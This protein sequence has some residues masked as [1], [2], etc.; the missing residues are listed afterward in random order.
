VPGSLSLP[1]HKRQ[2]QKSCISNEEREVSNPRIYI[3]IPTFH[4]QVGGAETQTL[5]QA[6]NLC[7]RGYAATVITFRHK[8]M[9]LPGEVIQGVPVI[10]VAGA[11][12]GG[13][14][15][16]P[17]PIQRLL[18]LLALLVMGWTLWRQRQC[19]DVLHVCQLGLL[20]LPAAI[21]CRLTGKPMLIVIISAAGSGLGKVTKSHGKASLIAGPP[22]ATTS[23][24]QAGRQTLIG[25]DLEGL[26][27]LGR[28]VVRLVRSL[29]H[30]THTPIVILSSRMR[31]YLA[32]HDFDLP[33]VQL[34]SN[35]VD[36]TRFEPAH[37]DTSTGG[38]E[39]VVVCV[40]KLRYEKGID[41]L[42]QAW[43]LVHQQA[44]QARLIIVGSGYLQTQLECMA[45]E[46]G[47]ANSVEFTGLQSDI[48]AQLHRGSL[49][50][51]PSRWEGMPNALLEAMACGLPCVATR[52]S[53]SEDIIQHGVN[54]LL[55]ESED[56]QG[57]AQALLTLLHDPV[58]A[59]R[60]GQAARETVE[61]HY[62]LERIMDRYVEL[63]QRIAERRC[64][65]VG[66]TP[67]SR[68][69]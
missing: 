60:Y 69:C 44:P 32:A 43:C 34:I 5:A 25:G 52:V 53:G 27:R 11:L 8:K 1:S 46:L 54:G 9:W 30:R 64:Q 19:Y 28:P 10:R 15:K 61:R 24:L 57:M 68:A 33:D 35:G 20:T 4:P 37:A 3:A 42:L 29:L 2:K 23:W 48:P 7:E 17:R 45:K 38:R 26:E 31:G 51:L 18:Y 49:T 36:I 67:S 50:V 40:S 55:V 16:L 47:I 13:R 56:Y 14:E 65:I 63:Y 59:Q 6:R 41:V 39:Q 22:G 58:L 62:S 21:V 12:L 66:D